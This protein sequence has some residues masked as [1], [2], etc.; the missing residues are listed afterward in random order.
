MNGAIGVT[1][2][3]EIHN[4]STYKRI[5]TKFTNHFID[6]YCHFRRNGYNAQDALQGAKISVQNQVAIQIVDESNSRNTKTIIVAYNNLKK[7]T[8]L[9]ER[10][11]KYYQGIK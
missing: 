8:C 9:I 11:I 5:Y 3:I 6:S 4:K 2:L 1:G 10:A 7:D